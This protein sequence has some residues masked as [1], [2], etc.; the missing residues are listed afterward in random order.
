[1]YVM[2]LP[3]LPACRGVAVGEA[4]DEAAPVVSYKTPAGVAVYTHTHTHAEDKN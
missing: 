4:A 2:L 1:M 3:L